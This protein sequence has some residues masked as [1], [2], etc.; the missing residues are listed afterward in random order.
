MIG[1]VEKVKKVAADGTTSVERKIRS[2]LP[3]KDV[4][5]DMALMSMR[6]AVRNLSLKRRRSTSEKARQVFQE[7][8]PAMLATISLAGLNFVIS[9]IENKVCVL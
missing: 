2:G 9:S 8:F 5:V 3:W 1:E 6:P 4:E 7:K